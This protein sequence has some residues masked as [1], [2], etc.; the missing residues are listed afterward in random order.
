M[1]S[2]LM[3]KGTNSHT[4]AVVL[5]HVASYPAAG[6]RQPVGALLLR[7]RSQ[8]PTSTG[9]WSAS[10]FSLLG[11]ISCASSLLDS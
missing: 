7:I 5:E 2:E 4:L 1:R 3:V 11:Y 8:V 10:Y 9:L 6:V